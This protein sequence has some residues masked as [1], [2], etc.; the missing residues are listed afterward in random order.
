MRM[1]TRLHRLEK[2]NLYCFQCSPIEIRALVMA[3]EGTGLEALSVRQCPACVCVHA[4]VCVTENF[5]GHRNV[6]TSP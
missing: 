1:Q 6:E 4:S 2:S 3:I 5:S